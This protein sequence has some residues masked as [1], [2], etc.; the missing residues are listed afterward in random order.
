MKFS[1][2]QEARCCSTLTAA[3]FASASLTNCVASAA[4]GVVDVDCI[5]WVPANMLS[6][7]SKV[8]MFIAPG[9]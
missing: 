3:S 2:T 7:M 6:A 8:V 9:V 1:A 5:C 4:V